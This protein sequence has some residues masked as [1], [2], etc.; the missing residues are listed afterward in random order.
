MAESKF[1]TKVTKY[2]RSRGCYVIKT[3][4]GPGIPMGC[5]DVIFMKE[6]F[7]GAVECKADKSKGYRPGQKETLE[8]FADWS[9][10]RRADPDNWE[11]VKEELENML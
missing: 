11:E 9:W 7:W 1:Q 2:L 5:P 6:G 4:P 3:R 10:A 8:K